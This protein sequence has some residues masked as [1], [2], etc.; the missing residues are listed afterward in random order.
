MSTV[1]FVMCE[2]WRTSLGQYSVG[3]TQLDTRL[4]TVFKLIAMLH[5]VT[6]QVYAYYYLICKNYYQKLNVT[7]Q[8]ETYFYH[9]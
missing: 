7:S 6:A 2:C 3:V 4:Q 9:K 5:N 8:V 1:L